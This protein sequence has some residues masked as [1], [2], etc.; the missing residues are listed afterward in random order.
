[1]FRYGGGFPV[2]KPRPEGTPR[3]A[4]GRGRKAR[5]ALGEEERVPRLLIYSEHPL[6]RAG[7]R[8]LLEARR[9]GVTVTECGLQRELMAA[10][11]AVRPEAALVE[12][13]P[14]FDLRLLQQM[15]EAARQCRFVLMAGTVA[16]ELLYHVTE[17]G[18][19]G[20]LSHKAP[21]ETLLEFVQAALEG[22]M[23][24]DPSVLP[25][26]Y[27]E[28]RIHLSPREAELVALLSQG[29]KNREIAAALGLS[30]GTVKVYLSHLFNK[31]HV[32]DRFELAL[33]GL[34]NMSLLGQG[35][36]IPPRPVAGETAGGETQAVILDW[37]QPA[38][39]RMRTPARRRR[40]ATG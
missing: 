12:L 17:S 35:A 30:E 8:C 29:C 4:A 31:L 11:A 10:L 38:S 22:R 20:V 15:Q 13:E 23:V 16:P 26:G 3:P 40:L 28:E 36:Q 32:K 33:Y 5:A 21:V 18:C 37:H 1:M 34:R 25:D 24:V 19:C 7:L 9:P 2:R 14:L 39:G 27:T 6:L